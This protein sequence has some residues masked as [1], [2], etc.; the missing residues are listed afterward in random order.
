MVGVLDGFGMSMFLPLLQMVNESSSVDYEGLGKFRFLIDFIE[1]LGV[2]INL[3]SVLLFMCFF[4]IMKGIAFFF[5][6]Y[7]QAIVQQY[8]IR[9]IRVQNIY[10]LNNLSY[11]AF[12]LSDVGQIQ[13]SLT[14]EVDR[15]AKAYDT[16]FAALQQSVMV[17]VYMAFAFFVDAQFAVLVSLGGFLTNLVYTRIYKQT[18]K[19]SFILTQNANNYQGLIIQYVGNFKY[20]KATAFLLEYANKLMEGV[21]RIE[22]GNR[23]IGILSALLRATREPLIIIVVTLV[24]FLQTS[25]FGASLGPILISLLFFYRALSSLMLMQSAWNSFL[26][27][28]GSLANMTAFSKKLEEGKEYTG[29]TRFPGFKSQIVLKD[30]SFSYSTSVILKDINLQINKNETIAFVGE[31]GSGKTTLVNILAGLMPL[32]KG[33]M[34]IDGMN[35]EDLDIKTYQQKI[36]YITQDPVIFNDTVFNN[37]SFWSD[38]TIENKKRFENALTKASLY[39]Y[40]QGL[41]EKEHTILGHNGINLSGGQKQRISIAR[42]LFKEIDILI[43]DEATSALDSETE[44]VIQENIDHLKGQYTILIVAHRLSTIRNANRIVLMRNGEITQIGSFQELTRSV[45]HFKRMVELQGL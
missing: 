1:G 6:G 35:R 5:Q 14:G 2:Q 28:S 33:Q 39:D 40:I 22:A 9:I 21:R 8:F 10:Q 43:L 4:F 19:A 12:A 27:V 34:S 15:I 29:K 20:L 32:D 37:V 36:G 13:N 25:V 44:K 23:K 18:K 38:P 31:S 41:P 7:Y 11:K 24:I 17:S 3:L 26:G 30:L 45:P 16:Y 42:E